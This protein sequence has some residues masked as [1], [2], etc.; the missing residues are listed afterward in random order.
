MSDDTGMHVVLSSCQAVVPELPSIVLEMTRWHYRQET[1]AG[2]RSQEVP[3]VV[4]NVWT[5]LWQ[6]RTSTLR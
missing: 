6:M 4:T 2:L 5:A 3:M 1:R